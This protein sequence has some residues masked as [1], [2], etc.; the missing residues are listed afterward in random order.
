MIDFLQSLFGDIV[1]AIKSLFDSISG[2]DGILGSEGGDGAGAG[3]GNTPGDDI[4]PG[5]DNGENQ[6]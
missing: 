2:S 4:T 5:T 1:E 6:E 3:D